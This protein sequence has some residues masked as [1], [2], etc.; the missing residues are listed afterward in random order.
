MVSA[1]GDAY[2]ASSGKDCNADAL[3]DICWLD[4]V[5]MD[6]KFHC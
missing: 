5:K 4:L 1:D 2:L 6:V 3:E